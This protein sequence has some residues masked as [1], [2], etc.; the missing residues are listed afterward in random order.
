MSQNLRNQGMLK[1]ACCAA[2]LFFFSTAAHG[3]STGKIPSDVIDFTAAHGK[4]LVLVGLDLPWQMESRLSQEDLLAQRTTIA[5]IQN[6]LLDK[7]AGRKFTVVRRYQEIPGI[8]LE[9]GADA[10]AELARLPIVTNVLLDR[11]ALPIQPQIID[12]EVAPGTAIGIL[13]SEKV[14]SSLFARA[15][16]DGTVLVLA[17]LKTPWQREDLLTD[18][19][20]DLQRNAIHG[21]QSYLLGELAGTHYKVMR[22]YGKIPGIALRVGVDALMIL[23][24]SPAITNV[25]PDRAAQLSR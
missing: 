21:V 14:P 19:L 11:P 7:L 1:L 5:S 16:R 3:Q 10:L 2:L 20:V 23:E 25:V 9:V 13:S 24:R 15:T 8:A 12:R 18:N 6:E 4:A 17:G 22:L